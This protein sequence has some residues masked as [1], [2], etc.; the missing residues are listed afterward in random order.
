MVKTC[1]ITAVQDSIDALA[2]SLFEALRGIRDATVASSPLTATKTNV[3]LT[4]TTMLSAYQGEE[5]QQE[6]D[7]QRQLVLQQQ[8]SSLLEN[9]KASKE[10]GTGGDNSS[11]SSSSSSNNI[12]NEA[13]RL[14]TIR[15][16][17][18][19]N[20]NYF[21]QKAYDMNNPDYE[22][23]LISYLSEDKYAKELI[24][25]MMQHSSTP[26]SNKTTK[27]DEEVSSSSSLS[28]IANELVESVKL[29]SSTSCVSSSSLNKTIKLPATVAVT[30]ATTDTATTTD[31]DNDNIGNNN[32]NN[33]MNS[34]S[35]TT[36]T[37]K[38]SKL[39][40]KL[41]VSSSSKQKQ[42]PKH[43]IESSTTTTTTTSSG[44][45]SSSSSTTSSSSSSSN[46]ILFPRNQKEYAQLLHSAQL[47]QDECITQQ[48]AKNV[49]SKSYTINTLVAN[50]PGIHRNRMNQLERICELIT[51]NHKLSHELQIAYE[52][53]N[54]RRMQVRCA[55]RENTCLAL[56][57]EE[58]EETV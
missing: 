28:S 55:L 18:G 38:K 53:A 29:P 37:K 44:N 49:L 39:S 54:V 6:E 23:F 22:S 33:M 21:P 19:L 15:L 9:S 11:S 47:L 40:I 51:L 46:D 8:I 36:T 7:E 35:P 12:D 26:I 4:T 3:D 56:G 25:N 43:I 42:L 52:V 34:S 5:E 10:D 2:L 45:S 57:I 48:L 30:S 1:P 27:K 32:D 50:L 58:E 24:H 16:L 31:G 41:N 17:Y 20:V 14:A 13:T